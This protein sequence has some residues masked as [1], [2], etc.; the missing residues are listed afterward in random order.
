[1]FWAPIISPPDP[2]PERQ[3]IQQVIEALGIEQE[4]WLDDVAWQLIEDPPN[5]MWRRDRDALLW[6]VVREMHSRGWEWYIEC[7]AVCLQG[8]GKYIKFGHMDDAMLYVAAKAL[9]VILLDADDD[10]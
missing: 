7:N 9:G 3:L 2:E 6:R 10:T 1:M 4:I 8:D 5:A